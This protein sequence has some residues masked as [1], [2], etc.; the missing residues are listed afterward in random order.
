MCVFCRRWRS[1][2]AGWETVSRGWRGLCESSN[3]PSR[4]LR[5]PWK[6][7]NWI[8][9]VKKIMLAGKQALWWGSYE[10][11]A[12]AQA[13]GHRNLLRFSSIEGAEQ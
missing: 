12:L 4:G 5:S 9:V 1:W 10:A 8:C 11:A 7:H 3:L 6:G 13:R 2:E